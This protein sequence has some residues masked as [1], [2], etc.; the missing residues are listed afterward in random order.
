MAAAGRRCGTTLERHRR[1]RVAARVRLS[2]SP[3]ASVAHV[4]SPQRVM[5]ADSG[6]ARLRATIRHPTG[7]D[8]NAL[9]CNRPPLSRG[10]G[11][12]LRAAPVR[13]SAMCGK[14]TALVSWRE[15]VEYSQVF[16]DIG[17]GGEGH[18]GD[19]GSAEETVTYRVG[20][21]LPMFGS[22]PHCGH[23]HQVEMRERGWRHARG[24]VG[25]ICTE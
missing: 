2:G 24:P 15:I 3:A 25:T 12:R 9:T 1:R 10:A 4:K 7:V 8:R 16:S 21:P 20:G 14:F 18:A 13:L 22:A 11:W 17:G 5:T 6:V 19:E 23:S